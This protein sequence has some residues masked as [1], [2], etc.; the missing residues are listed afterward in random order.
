MKE[1]MRVLISAGRD[2]SIEMFDYCLPIYTN[3]NSTWYKTDD[4]YICVGN[5]VDGAVEASNVLLEGYNELLKQAYMEACERISES[6]Q[7]VDE[8]DNV[9]TDI[10]SRYTF[11]ELCNEE[12]YSKWI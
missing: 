6:D 4:A 1:K 12:D 10:L 8:Y 7:L 5:S 2:P 3:G 9:V 11:S